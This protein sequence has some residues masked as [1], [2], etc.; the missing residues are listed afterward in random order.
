MR[1]NRQRRITLVDAALAVLARDG[2][3]A[4]TFRAVDAQARL[5][6]GTAS[7]Y[8]KNRDVLLTQAGMRA[9]DRLTPDSPT[10]GSLLETAPDRDG[11]A[12]L[13]RAGLERLTRSH[14]LYL[15]LLELRL[16]AVRR[17]ELRS[18]LTAR[19][20]EDLDANA[21]LREDGTRPGD[22]TAAMLLH[23]AFNWLIVERLTLPELI[24]EDQAD[25]LVTVLVERL[26]SPPAG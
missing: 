3:R 1:H 8:F 10:M 4:L 19:L 17:P 6:P 9:Y 23:L 13:V 22:A 11:V 21:V 5:P 26:V 15:A 2:A 16:E 24:T 18:V 12:R 14:S 25:R 7:N 20:R